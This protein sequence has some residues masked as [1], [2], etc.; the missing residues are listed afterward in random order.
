[1]KT[2]NQIADHLEISPQRLYYWLKKPDAPHFIL[3]SLRNQLIRFYDEDEV[4]KMY[5]ER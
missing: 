3:K 1:M 4:I 5:Q 2:I